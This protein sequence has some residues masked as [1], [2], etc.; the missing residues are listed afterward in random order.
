MSPKNPDYPRCFSPTFSGQPYLDSTTKN[1]SPHNRLTF[2]GGWG[3]CYEDPYAPRPASSRCAPVGCLRGNE[4]CPV[5]L[6]T[7]VAL[8]FTL[9]GPGTLSLR[10][11]FAG[12]GSPSSLSY[13][14]R[15][16]RCGPRGRST[17]A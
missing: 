2:A 5:V 6:A 1:P 7:E 12:A 13:T 14:A 4:F 10:P 11:C 17:R 15:E 16:A 9:G 3:V 8:C